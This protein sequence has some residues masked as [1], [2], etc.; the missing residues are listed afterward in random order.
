MEKHALF[1]RTKRDIDAL[2]RGGFQTDFIK[3]CVAVIVNQKPVCSGTLISNE[4]VL[5]AGHCVPNTTTTDI[6]VVAGET[7]LLSFYQG[8]SK[9][10]IKTSVKNIKLHPNFK[11]MHT[12]ILEKDLA[13][14]ELEK[15]LD[16]ENNPN[17][18]VAFLPS[19]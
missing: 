19:N 1:F 16:I 5:T 7:N 11:W 3:T 6:E 8:L 18:E 15:P 12:K 9:T 17:I 13:L 4:W 2:I 14:L 10:G